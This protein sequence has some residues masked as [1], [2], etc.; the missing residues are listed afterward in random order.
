V[1]AVRHTHPIEHRQLPG[2][3]PIG[4][5]IPFGCGNPGAD[6]G[7]GTPYLGGP[8][9]PHATGRSGRRR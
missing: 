8:P 7:P 6:V 3:Q 4:Q 2:S 9:R 1:A 5:L